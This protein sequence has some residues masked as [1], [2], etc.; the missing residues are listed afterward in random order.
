MNRFKSDDEII[1][2][3]EKDIEDLEKINENRL[4]K[5]KQLQL[6]DESFRIRN[7]IEWVIGINRLIDK[8]KYALIINYVN[9]KVNH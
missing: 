9:S 3:I 2:Y 4:H 8:I 1:D 7:C 5:E 6:N